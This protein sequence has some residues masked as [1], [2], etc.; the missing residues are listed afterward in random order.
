MTERSEQHQM[1]VLLFI[2]GFVV[3]GIVSFFFAG[4]LS[5][6]RISQYELINKKLCQQNKRLADSLPEE[7][8]KQISGSDV[9]V[10][11]GKPIP[12]GEM[13]CTNCLREKM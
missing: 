13:V 5:A 8:G 11:C 6:Q 10:C 7:T 4:A 12:E 2:L 3:G 1:E 9:C